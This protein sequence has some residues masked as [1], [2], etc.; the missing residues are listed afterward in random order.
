MKAFTSPPTHHGIFAQ[1]VMRTPAV[2][3]SMPYRVHEIFKILSDTGHKCWYDPAKKIWVMTGDSATDV[4]K[5]IV[6]VV[7]QRDL[8]DYK[9]AWRTAESAVEIESQ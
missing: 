2:H 9:T 4:L 8:S 3:V 1:V 7:C 5:W 6:Q